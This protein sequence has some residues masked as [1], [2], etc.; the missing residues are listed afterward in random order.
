MTQ[1]ELL[2][3]VK[4]GLSMTGTF[5]DNV[6]RQKM[7]AVTTYMT[8]AGIDSTNLYSDLGIACIIVGVTDLWDLSPGEIK[9]SPVFGMLVEQLAVKSIV[10]S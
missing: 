2:S 6:L 9:F 3:A 7:L 10:E 1:G 4:T 5:N 8:N